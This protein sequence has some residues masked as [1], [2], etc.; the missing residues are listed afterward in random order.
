MGNQ[1][2][3][4]MDVGHATFRPGSVRHGGH[5]VTDG[6]RYILGAFLLLQD[7]VE[8]V[9]R[10]K[11]RGSELRRVPAL[12]GAAKHFEWAL[13]LNPKCTTVSL[14]ERTVLRS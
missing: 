12:E 5:R 2:I 3:L 4:A 7:R 1:N 9:R 11:N 8:H 13:A 6:T 14:Y 10:L